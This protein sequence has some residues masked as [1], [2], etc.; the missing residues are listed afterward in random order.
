MLAK[1]K[2]ELPRIRKR[3][4]KNQRLLFGDF[5]G[6]LLCDLKWPEKLHLEAFCFI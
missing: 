2:M 1:I 5:L 3:E 4:I 6:S